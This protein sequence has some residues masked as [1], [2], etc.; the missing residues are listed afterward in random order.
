MMIPYALVLPSA[1]TSRSAPALSFPSAPPAAAT[2]LASFSATAKFIAPA[3][4]PAVPDMMV[5]SASV[6]YGVPSCVPAAVTLILPPAVTLPPLVSISAM[7]VLSILASPTLAPTPTKP[8]VSAVLVTVVSPFMPAYTVISPDASMFAPLMEAKSSALLK[9][10]AT[11][12]FTPANPPAARLTPNT[13]VSPV[14]LESTLTLCAL[15]LPVTVP[16]CGSVSFSLASASAVVGSLP[17]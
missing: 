13:L 4:T 15:T 10:S 3:N 11:A 1:V 16:L 5:V 17:I 14:S 8:P 7:L 6:S 12:P 2:F 9:P